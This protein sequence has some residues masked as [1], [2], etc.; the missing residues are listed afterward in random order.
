MFQGI[1]TVGGVRVWALRSQSERG[2]MGGG[3][4]GGANANNVG[5]AVGA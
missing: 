2:R 1:G 5:F 3:P 4:R